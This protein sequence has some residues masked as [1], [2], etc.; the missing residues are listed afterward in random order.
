MTKQE[1][2]VEYSVQ[3]IIE[4]IV[5]EHHVEYDVAMKQFYESQTFS[6]L[7]DIDTGLYLESSA[8]VY[9]I[10]QNELN[11]GRIVQTEI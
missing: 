10:F 5:N 6:K 11:F 1:Q 3:D 2:L 4:Y 8:Y 7:N 9:S